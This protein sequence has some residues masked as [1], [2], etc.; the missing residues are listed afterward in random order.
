MLALSG[1]PISGR[2]AGLLTESDDRARIVIDTKHSAGYIL[3]QN[4]P[5]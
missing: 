5:I 3:L 4:Q 1:F 2:A